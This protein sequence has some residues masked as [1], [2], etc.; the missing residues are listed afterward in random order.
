MKCRGGIVG[1]LVL[2]GSHAAAAAAPHIAATHPAK[3]QSNEAPHDITISGSGFIP[4]GSPLQALDKQRVFLRMGTQGGFVE[5][6]MEIPGSQGWGESG[7][8]AKYP[9]GLTL[10][11]GGLQIKVIVNG[12]E[13]NVFSIPVIAPP[14]PAVPH[15]TSIWHAETVAGS[16]DYYFILRVSGTGIDYQTRP[17]FQGQEDIPFVRS[18]VEGFVQFS[19]PEAYRHQ[20]GRYSV[21]LVNAQ[22][23]SNFG[24]WDLVV[25][26]KLAQLAPPS[27]SPA[28]L[29]TPLAVTLTFE[30]SSPKQV[31]RRVDGGGWAPVAHGPIVGYS[32]KVQLDLP[33]LKPE[34]TIDLKLSNAA[35]ESNVLTLHVL[36]P[37]EERR[38]R[39]PPHHPPQM[40]KKK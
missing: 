36:A 28:A 26:P 11:P 16:T 22:G 7:F 37:I 38:D 23:Y 29:T 1:A 12:V 10:A 18:L 33:A 21:Q 40:P 8:S 30:G 34:K 25:K 9:S 20:P 24:W 14:P 35:G 5:T 27:I 3:I 4:A 15:I 6:P 31:L 2:L 17:R 39:V 13:S 32:T 19:V